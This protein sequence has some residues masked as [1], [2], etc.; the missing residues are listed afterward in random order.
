MIH[1]N[2]RDHTQSNWFCLLEEKK[3][4]STPKVVQMNSFAETGSYKR[5]EGLYY[6]ICLRGWRDVLFFFFMSPAS[7]SWE[8]SLSYCPQGAVLL[9]G[10]RDFCVKH[11]HRGVG[12]FLQIY[13][14]SKSWTGSTRKTV[15]KF[16]SL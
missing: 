2:F 1:C 7:P 12:N 11:I 15:V 9:M 13:H 16:L 5:A 14:H 10:N 6:P 8:S 4:S 3:K